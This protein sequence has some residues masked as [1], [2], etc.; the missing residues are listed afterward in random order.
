MW[1]IT[2]AWILLKSVAKLLI[3]SYLGDYPVVRMLITYTTKI[4]T[5]IAIVNA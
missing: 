4:A 3:M 2:S 1:D 5:L